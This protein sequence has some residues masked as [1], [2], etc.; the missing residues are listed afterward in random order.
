VVDTPTGL[1]FL[2]F[3]ELDGWVIVAVKERQ[4]M[5]EESPDRRETKAL[6]SQDQWVDVPNKREGRQNIAQRRSHWGTGNK[7]ELLPFDKVGVRATG[8]SH[9]LR[10]IANQHIK[11]EL[12]NFW[13]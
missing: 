1:V 5:A 7:Q 12:L 11:L 3:I 10:L 13:L 8:A 6:E 2:N 9:E 4:E